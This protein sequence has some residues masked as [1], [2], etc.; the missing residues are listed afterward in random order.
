MSYEAKPP[1]KGEEES[2]P[3]FYGG[4]WYNKRPSLLS[5]SLSLSIPKS[6]VAIT[7]VLLQ[8]YDMEKQ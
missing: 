1:K 5:L 2:P 8:A 3:K 7:G 4:T 6:F